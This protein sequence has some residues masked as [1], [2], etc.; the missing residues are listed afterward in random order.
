MPRTDRIERNCLVCAGSFLG[1]P[2][3]T[4]CKPCKQAGRQVRY[5]SCLECRQRFHVTDDS[6]RNCKPCADLLGLDQSELSPEK[7][8]ARDQAE[9]RKWLREE[10]QREGLYV[11]QE[12]LRRFIERRDAQLAWLASRQT[13]TR[14]FIPIDPNDNL[15]AR[16]RLL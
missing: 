3:A 10:L 2:K 1:T 12:R 7:Q 5:R 15:A 14:P 11:E 13:V 8:A 4:R 9:E 16:L 6:H